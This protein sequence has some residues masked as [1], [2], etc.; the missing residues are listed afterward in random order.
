[1]TDI[2]RSLILPSPTEQPVLIGD[3]VVLPSEHGGYQN[4]YAILRQGT[5]QVIDLAEELLRDDPEIPDPQKNPHG[6]KQQAMMKYGIYGP[7]PSMPATMGPYHLARLRHIVKSEPDD[8]SPGFKPLALEHF[9][10]LNDPIIALLRCTTILIEQADSCG[11]LR[12]VFT[13]FPAR[14][15]S[16]IDISGE[17]VGDRINW[18]PLREAQRKIDDFRREHLRSVLS[19]QKV[20]DSRIIDGTLQTRILS[21][22]S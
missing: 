20:L 16:I 1:M 22:R 17:T 6:H 10:G 15:L 21:A 3:I 13:D 9:I 8:Y 19:W 12:P 18:D 7:I 5:T 2:E 4:F 14:D 11:P